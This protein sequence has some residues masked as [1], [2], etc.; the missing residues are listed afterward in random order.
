MVKFFL[1]SQ[2]QNK[3]RKPGNGHNFIHSVAAP[4]C[5]VLVSH[6]LNVLG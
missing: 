3:E 6:S 4:V 2:E 1:K 5:L